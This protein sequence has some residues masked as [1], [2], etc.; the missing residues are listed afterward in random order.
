VQTI[1]LAPT[2]LEFFG[3]AP[4]P[5][6]EGL[7]LAATIADD[8]PVRAAGLYGLFGAQVNVTD[9]RY[10]YMRGPADPRHNRP[11]YEYTLMPT[12]M[13]T[14]FSPAELRTA[15]MA[16]PFPF[17]KGAPVMRIEALQPDNPDLVPSNLGTALYDLAADPHQETPIQDAAIEARMLAHLVALMR[18]NHAP[19]E[20]F[21]RL[22]LPC[23]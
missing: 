23:S 9:G 4:T 20:Q 13:R 15:A 2:L 8:C 7:P 14:L 11:L 21:E 18:A 3:V 10:V 1:D 22:G 16:P 5:D 19:A 17:T 6:M 12:H